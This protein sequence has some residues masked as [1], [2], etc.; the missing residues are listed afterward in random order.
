VFDVGLEENRVPGSRLDRPGPDLIICS[1][2][3]AGMCG[4]M[5]ATCDMTMGGVPTVMM[6]TNGMPMMSLSMGMMGCCRMEKTDDGMKM[7]CTS[8]D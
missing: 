2:E 1:C 4:M 6:M 8:G 7:C 5:H 3:D